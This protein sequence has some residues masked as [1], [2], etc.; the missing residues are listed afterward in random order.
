MEIPLIIR[1][2]KYDLETISM[3][4]H[5]WQIICLMSY[6]KTSIIEEIITKPGVLIVHNVVNR[7]NS[8]L[9]HSEIYANKIP[10]ND[11]EITL[12][13]MWKIFSKKHKTIKE[14]HVIPEF[15]KLHVPRTLFEDLGVKKWFEYSFP[16]CEIT[17]W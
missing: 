13:Y 10:I 14:L 1:D 12:D 3:W 7:D 9:E 2:S 6:E 17:F 8:Q 11:E 4:Q 5:I 16:N 15:K